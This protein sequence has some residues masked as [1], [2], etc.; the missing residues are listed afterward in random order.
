MIKLKRPNKPQVLDNQGNCKLKSL[1]SDL[2]Y[3]YDLASE[4]FEDD[5]EKFEFENKVYGH[6]RIKEALRTAQNGKCAFCEQNVSSVDYG[7]IEHFRPKGGYKQNTKDDMHKPGYYWLAYEWKNLLFV[8]KICNQGNK[9]NLFPIRRPE[10]RSFNHYLSHEIIKEKPFFINPYEENP[11]N[12]IEFKREMASGK[13]K[14]H[15]G[16]KTIELFGLNRKGRGF[17]DIYELRKDYYNLVKQTYKI[18]K[19]NAGKDFSQE[20]IDEAKSLMDEFR[21]KTKQF[22]A[23]INDNFPR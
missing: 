15:R 16:K 22:S 23:M 13:D 8:C 7:D 5:I 12:L 2:C 19:K 17:N 9:K 21:S 6:S 1:T 20:E 3:K 11:R 10:F 14:N 18:S 4:D